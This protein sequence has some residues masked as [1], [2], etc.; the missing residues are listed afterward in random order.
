MKLV[1][2]RMEPAFG[3]DMERHDNFISKNETSNHKHHKNEFKKHASGHK[4]HM[5]IV[6]S[7]CKGGKA[8]G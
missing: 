5:D 1:K 6:E 4:H 7:M 2:E 3:P 8:V